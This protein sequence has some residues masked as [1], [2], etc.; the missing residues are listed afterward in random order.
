[1]GDKNLLST[2]FQFQNTKPLNSITIGNIG[3]SIYVQKSEVKVSNSDS[4]SNNIN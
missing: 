1:M 4:S 2:L 3:W